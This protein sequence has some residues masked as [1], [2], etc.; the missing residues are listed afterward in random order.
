M[1]CSTVS[2]PDHIMYVRM[3][4]L[5]LVSTKI[6]RALALFLAF[7]TVSGYKYLMYTHKLVA[8]VCT[9]IHIYEF[10]H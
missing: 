7:H 1:K 10:V 6:L 2:V 4:M 5:L 8:L 9:Y 3:Y